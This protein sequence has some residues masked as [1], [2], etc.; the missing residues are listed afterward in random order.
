MLMSFRDLISRD[1]FILLAA[2]WPDSYNPVLLNCLAPAH[3]MET[4]DGIVKLDENK[5]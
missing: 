4:G 2:T 5:K 3:P 1:L